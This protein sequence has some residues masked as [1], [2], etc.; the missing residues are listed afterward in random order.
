MVHKFDALNI[1]SV[2]LKL[3]IT[4]RW[5]HNRDWHKNYEANPRRQ[6]CIVDCWLGDGVVTIALE[7]AATS[8]VLFRWLGYVVRLLWC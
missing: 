4:A 8:Q 1:S 7:D 6:V 2:G 3:T 5:S